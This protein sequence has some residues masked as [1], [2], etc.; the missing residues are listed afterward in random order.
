MSHIRCRC[1][2]L[3]YTVHNKL[4]HISVTLHENIFGRQNCITVE[5]VLFIVTRTH[6]STEPLAT[7]PDYDDSSWQFSMLHDLQFVNASRACKKRPFGRSIL[8]SRSHDCLIGSHECLLLFWPAVQS[9]QRG[10]ST[11]PGVTMWCVCGCS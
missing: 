10:L 11:H 1:G 6:Y 5:Y 2:L 9:L 7:G 4:Y 3:L 8:Q